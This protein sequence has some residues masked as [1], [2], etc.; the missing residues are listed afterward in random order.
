MPE[1]VD[2][3]DPEL[4]EPKGVATAT[5]GE[6]YVA[7]GAGS[8]AW[9]EVEPQGA[10]AAT[11]GQL[12]VADGAG[13]GSFQ[14]VGTNTYIR[15][16]SN[17]ANTTAVAAATD[18]ALPIIGNGSNNFSSGNVGT[19]LLELDAT[20]NGGTGGI[21]TDNHGLDIDYTLRV[22]FENLGTLGPVVVVKAFLVFDKT[23]PGTGVQISTSPITASSGV[24]QT[25]ILNFF[26]NGIEAIYVQINSDLA[27]DYELKGVYITASERRGT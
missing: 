9:G 25:A 11:V 20:F 1:H 21:I 2:L 14:H 18:T 16:V 23:V 26:G 6:V 15:N 17:A 10:A 4:H 7:N 13:S 19:G 8:G 24:E 12:Y 27:R 22:T 3:T 5:S